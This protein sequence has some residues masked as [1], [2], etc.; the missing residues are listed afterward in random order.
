[1]GALT[2]QELR[3]KFNLHY[4]NVTSGVAPGLN[5]YEISLFMTQAFK[6]IVYNYY[7]GTSKGEAVDDT[8]RMKALLA[9]FTKQVSLTKTAEL[10][11]PIKTGE[12]LVA[13]L[14]FNKVILPDAIQFLLRESVKQNSIN[15][16]VKP[17][18]QDEFWVLSENPFKKPNK[19]RAWRLDETS[20]SATTRE[21]IIVSYGDIQSYSATYINKQQPIILSTL[22]DVVPGMTL[23]IEGSSAASLPAVVI[24]NPWFADLIVNRAVELATR[25]YKANAL[26]TQMALN[27]RVE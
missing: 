9:P 17:I 19:F 14:F 4:D 5:D 27:T 20:D 12:V 2:A 15:V 10:N 23:T 11:S 8:E 24:N 13:G 26:E 25:D 3:Y 18:S 1:M 7:N 22:T 16:L 21:L 6:E